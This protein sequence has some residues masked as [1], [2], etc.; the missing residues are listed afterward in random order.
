MMT[1]LIPHIFSLEIIDLNNHFLP[2]NLGKSRLIYNTHIFIHYFNYLELKP[3]INTIL[4]NINLIKIGY[5]N[6]TAENSTISK[7]LT[8]ISS[9][10]L[11]F[12]F[13]QLID[14]YD[15]L[16]PSIKPRRVRRGLIDPIGNL[17]KAAF[18]LLDAN[19]GECIEAAIKALGNN[20]KNLYKSMNRQM[21]LSSKLIE[22]LNTSLSII[23]DNQRNI[24]SHIK[25][26]ENR[27][28]TFIMT[29]LKLLTL[30]NIA[31]QITNNC[32]LLITLIDQL[33]N[34]IM[35]AHLHAIHPSIVRSNE[36]QEMINILETH[37]DQNN[38]IKFSSILSYYK[39]LTTQVFFEEG[40][41]IFTI[42]FPLITRDEFKLYQIIPIPQNNTLYYPTTFFL[43]TTHLQN[44]MIQQKCPEIENTLY[45]AQENHQADDCML[46]TT[47]LKPPTNCHKR[48]I[49]LRTTLTQKI[50]N[51][52]IV[53]PKPDETATIT[54]NGQEQI[55]L[56]NQPV[57]IQL[58][59]KCI[60]EVNHV[61][62]DA[63]AQKFTTSPL[64]LPKIELPIDI[65]K[66]HYE[67]IEIRDP[68]LEKIQDLKHIIQHPD[69][70]IPTDITAHSY[71]GLIIFLAICLAVVA[72][73]LWYRYYGCS[74]LKRPTAATLLALQPKMTIEPEMIALQSA[75]PVKNLYPRVESSSK[76]P[77]HN[78][79]Q[80]VSI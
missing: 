70:L 49:I 47:S 39:L 4:A 34:A 76:L 62:F 46:S 16:Q 6:L 45:C 22:R 60:V 42:N 64:L 25:L 80:V 67:P 65:S 41:I 56:I 74:K 73:Y 30:Q 57:L 23:T 78:C 17:Y 32:A 53:V 50:D 72:T 8:H 44:L 10:D 2:I 51:N 31:R 20:Q 9:T 29:S 71:T 52:L 19:D 14:K 59:N 79:N 48:S 18:G 3:Q 40:R 38:V 28:D 75:V 24:A 12:T 43:L 33:E 11:D 58:Q 54:C 27:Y 7:T 69:P 63:T 21:S 36:I 35:F 26:L 61:K 13:K 5:K 15:N 55:Q 68:E 66:T 37:Y 1:Y 77:S